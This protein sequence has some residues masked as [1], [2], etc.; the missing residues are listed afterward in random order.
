MRSR[1]ATVVFTDG[2]VAEAFDESV[3]RCVT[4]LD[5][6][7]A[8]PHGSI[9]A[10]LCDRE[11]LSLEVSGAVLTCV[12]L[13]QV[14]IDVA[15]NI[16]DDVEDPKIQGASG[17]SRRLMPTIVCLPALILAQVVARLASLCKRASDD[18]F[19]IERLLSTL[20]TMAGGQS[21]TSLAKVKATSGLQGLVVCLPLWL[22]GERG[23]TAEDE[24]I[25]RWAVALGET[26][27]RLIQA[28][29]ED[30]PLV[31][32]RY[33]NAVQRLMEAW[34]VEEIF[35]RDGPLGVYALGFGQRLE[36]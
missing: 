17:Y 10:A 16:A 35:E 27:E 26:W 28:L 13:I 14:A 34:P 29:E 15:D 12:D 9:V 23:Q 19:A 5:L 36:D 20:E 11:R 6:A 3:T 24:A 1:L 22:K 4:A 2:C 18:G 8:R 33:H 25:E 31:R 21:Q 7:Q 30:R 32:A